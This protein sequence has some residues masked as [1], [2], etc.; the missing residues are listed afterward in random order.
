LFCKKKDNNVNQKNRIS[1]HIKQ[2][3]I[4]RW[5]NKEANCSQANS[6]LT[7]MMDYDFRS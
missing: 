4:N 7:F 6:T 2:Y 5:K 3:Y 1:K